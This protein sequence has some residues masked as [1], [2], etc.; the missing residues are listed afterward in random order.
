MMQQQPSKVYLDD[1]PIAVQQAFKLIKER[2]DWTATD[3]ER[4]S[5]V[6]EVLVARPDFQEIIMNHFENND[7]EALAFTIQ[8]LAYLRIEQAIYFLKMMPDEYEKVLL[9]EVARFNRTY[10]TCG[11]RFVAERNNLLSR[12]ETLSKL[13]M[14]S[15][16][17]SA[18]RRNFILSVLQ[19]T[20]L[21]EI[22]Q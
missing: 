21:E 20:P 13:N 8:T 11:D 19:H 15:R 2:E 9:G 6:F 14:L 22:H 16:I 5:Q 18:E 17:F 4:L 1:L 10:L 7:Q 12:L 3:D